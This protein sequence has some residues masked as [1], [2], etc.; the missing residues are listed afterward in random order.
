MD[1][2]LFDA[3]LS[4]ASTKMADLVVKMGTIII[5]MLLDSSEWVLVMVDLFF[6]MHL[7]G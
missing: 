7:Y 4:D 6:S 3:F 2:F 1:S 5:S